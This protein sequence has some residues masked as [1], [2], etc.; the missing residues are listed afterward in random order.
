MDPNP[1]SLFN[2]GIAGI[3]VVISQ[4]KTWVHFGWIDGSRSLNKTG[5]LKFEKFPDSNLD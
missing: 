2:F 4:V 1:K 5:I 3:W